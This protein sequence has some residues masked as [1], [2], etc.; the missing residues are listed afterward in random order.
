MRRLAASLTSTAGIALQQVRRAVAAMVRRREQ[1]PYK[2]YVDGVRPDVLAT[3]RDLEAEDRVSTQLAFDPDLASVKLDELLRQRESDPDAA[4]ALAAL[5]AAGAV[6]VENEGA[7]AGA[8]SASGSWVH[9][10]AM[11]ARAS[12][13]NSGTKVLMVGWRSRGPCD[14]E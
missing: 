10:G 7:G 1:G 6:L 14:S 5:H 9:A 11:H 12:R 2:G 4:T 13:A 3:E 8:G